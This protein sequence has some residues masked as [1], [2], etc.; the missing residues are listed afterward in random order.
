LENKGI[1]RNKRKILAA[2]NNAS[3]F[4]KIEKDF[5]SFRAYLFSFTG[6][7]VFFEWDRTTSPLSDAISLDLKKRGMKFV[8]STVIYSFLQAI[9]I[10]NSHEPGCFLYRE[11]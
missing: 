1:I 8:G 4:L 3:V 6:E 9:G 2:I 5:G 11:K 10:V 7:E